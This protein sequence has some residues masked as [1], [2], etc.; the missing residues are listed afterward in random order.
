MPI[1]GG[2]PPYFTYTPRYQKLST[3]KKIFCKKFSKTGRLL[4]MQ[5][6]TSRKE[7]LAAGD[8]RYLGGPCKYGH[9][10][11]RYTRNHTCLE[12]NRKY[13]EQ[14]QRKI[15]ERRRELRKA[16]RKRYPEKIKASHARHRAEKL[17]RL[18][19]WITKEDIRVMK[20]FYAEA[21]RKTLATGVKY[22]VDHIIP[23]KG[24]I[25]SGLHVPSNLQIITATENM[26]KYNVYV[27]K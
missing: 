27:S 25:V 1:Q 20:E 18:P 11:L 10:G 7:A 4:C 14:H 3:G 24:E 17:K 2:V 16:Y 26:Q 8:I 19:K 12:C 6:K 22:Q 5:Y 23:L 9:K 21:T 15:P 13:T